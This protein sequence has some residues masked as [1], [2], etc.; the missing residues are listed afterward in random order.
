[1][2]SGNRGFIATVLVSLL[3]LAGTAWYLRDVWSASE[4]KKAQTESKVR[5]Y[6]SE[7]QGIENIDRLNKEFATEIGVETKA[8]DAYK[9]AASFAFPAWVDKVNTLTIRGQKRE[10]FAQMKTEEADR[11]RQLCGPECQIQYGNVLDT[12]GF[13]TNATPT[14]EEAPVELRRLAIVTK[15][16]DLAARA[17]RDQEQADTQE[18]FK[19]TAFLKLI[20]VEPLKPEATGAVRLDLNPKFKDNSHDYL[21]NRFLVVRYPYFMIEYPIE[22]KMVCDINTFRRFLAATREPNQYLIIRNIRIRSNTLKMSLE[23]YADY[24]PELGASDIPENVGSEVVY[25]EL[26]AAGVEFLDKHRYEA[27]VTENLDVVNYEAGYAPAVK[28]TTGAGSPKPR[29][30][31]M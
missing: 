24:P 10:Y 28:A 30:V 8:F 16:I 29:P 23:G 26:S 20:K 9:R 11:L 14:D 27:G 4:D 22:L 2:D 19:S 13:D 5:Q 12:L 3:V 31:G 21:N 15:T 25:I 17:K 7:F 6:D 1:M 18:H